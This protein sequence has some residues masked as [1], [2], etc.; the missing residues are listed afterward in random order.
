[1]VSPERA[2]EI[3]D[4]IH[5]V[6]RRAAGRGDIVGLLLVGSC[7]RDAARPDSDVDFVLL[8]HDPNGYTDLAIG[9]P[10]RTQAWGIITEQRFRTASGLE[11]EIGIGG[12]EWASVTPV[13]PG[14]R[15]VVTDGA[16]IL[17]DPTGILAALL[18]ACRP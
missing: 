18:N 3:D 11:I 13:D 7:A 6:T 5:R 4:V 10:I 2:A 17:H 1:M 12:P 16:R 8:T 9:E 14:T 15:R